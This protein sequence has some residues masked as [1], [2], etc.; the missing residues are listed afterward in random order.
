MTILAIVI[1]Q[2]QRMT[3]IVE[4][5]QAQPQTQ[6]SAS[7]SGDPESDFV[8]NV[9]ALPTEHISISNTSKGNKRVTVDPGQTQAI[10]FY[11]AVCETQVD[12][13]SAIAAARAST[14]ERWVCLYH[15]CL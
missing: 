13:N 14:G 6:I 5:A 10:H 15:C 11:F 4:F 8:D 9:T 7:K 1:M 12:A 3:G 2:G